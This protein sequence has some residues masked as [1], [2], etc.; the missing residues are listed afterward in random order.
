MRNSVMRRIASGTQKNAAGFDP[1]GV[2]VALF[3]D[4]LAYVKLQKAVVDAYYGED[5]AH[6][7]LKQ[8]LCAHPRRKRSG[9]RNYFDAISDLHAA[10][11]GRFSWRSFH[12]KP[13]RRCSPLILAKS[14]TED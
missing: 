8:Y 14:L 1:N 2:H 9:H 7:S 10:P 4:D 6:A 3:T 12:T 5:A 13:S 11:F